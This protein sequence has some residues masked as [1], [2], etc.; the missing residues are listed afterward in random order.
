MQGG[1]GEGLFNVGRGGEHKEHCTRGLLLSL[2]ERGEP[3][4]GAVSR[5]RKEGLTGKASFREVT[6]SLEA[7]TMLPPFPPPSSCPPSYFPSMPHGPKP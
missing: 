4:E 7:H 5:V 3:E 1:L 2:E 6:T